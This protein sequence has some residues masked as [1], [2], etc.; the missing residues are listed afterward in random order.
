MLQSSTTDVV[1]LAITV[2]EKGIFF[3]Q[4]VDIANCKAINSEYTKRTPTVR[5]VCNKPSFNDFLGYNE[6]PSAYAGVLG[7][8]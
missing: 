4:L 7:M 1:R 5:P 8:V 2:R 6:L 3:I